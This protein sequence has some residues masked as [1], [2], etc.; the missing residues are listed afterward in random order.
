MSTATAPSASTDKPK[1]NPIKR[2]HVEQYESLTREAKE[3]ERKARALKK[4]LDPLKQ[5]LMAHAMASPKQTIVRFGHRISVVAGRV[6]PSWKDWI[7]KL[8]G[9]MKVAEIQEKTEPSK[10][11]EV[12][13]L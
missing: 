7:V 2:E 5:N 4:Q 8:C 11:L 6:N 9:A 10:V 12:E 13:L 3:L 1:L